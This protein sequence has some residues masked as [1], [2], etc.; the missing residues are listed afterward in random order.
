L[1]AYRRTKSENRKC[2][3]PL[4]NLL[5]FELNATV[6]AA[7]RR[8]Q[9]AFLNGVP[10]KPDVRN[11]PVIAKFILNIW[12]GSAIGISQGLYIEPWAKTF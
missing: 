6:A 9:E 2:G 12:M 8:Y 10:G 5:Q 7:T 1:S 3:R 11:S 4:R